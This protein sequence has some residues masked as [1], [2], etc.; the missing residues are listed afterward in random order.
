[1]PCTISWSAWS[2]RAAGINFCV[3]ITSTEERY[4]QWFAEKQYNDEEM[5]YPQKHVPHGDNTNLCQ[6]SFH[7]AWAELLHK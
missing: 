2:Q 6:D 1:M 5:W 3:K 7:V 4:K